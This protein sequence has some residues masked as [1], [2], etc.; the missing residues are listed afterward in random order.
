MVYNIQFILAVTHREIIMTSETSDCSLP[1]IICTLRY[2]S[3]EMNQLEHSDQLCL[4]I[5]DCFVHTQSTVMPRS[6]K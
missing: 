4:H 6:L 5:D 2:G 1:R 3:Y